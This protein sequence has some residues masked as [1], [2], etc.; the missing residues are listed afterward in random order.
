[1]PEETER[2]E[3]T[4]KTV[5]PGLLAGC[6]VTGK[7]VL[8]SELEKSAVTGKKAL[9]GLFVSSSISGTRLLEEEAIRSA[10]GKYCVPLETKACTWS[11]RRCHPDDLRTCQLT[12]ITAHFEYMTR[13]RGTCLEPLSNLLHGILRRAERP[14]LW[15]EII[16]NTSQLLGGR[17]R[18]AAAEASPDGDHLA[19]CVETKNWLGLSIREG[20][21]L[22]S[23]RDNVATGRIVLGK[24][25][26]KGWRLEK[27]F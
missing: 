6:E 4:G 25:E 20:G 11:S 27:T 26:A 23:V 5:I 3:V 22:Y 15:P 7:R 17:S 10:T 8:A 19:V 16:A 2:C 14:E 21:L 1:M 9:K 13:E 18:V 12:G 24:R